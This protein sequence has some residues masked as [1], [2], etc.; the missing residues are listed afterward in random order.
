[1]EWC[2]APHRVMLTM[3]GRP[4]S[5]CMPGVMVHAATTGLTTVPIALYLTLMFCL[6]AIIPSARINTINTPGWTVGVFF[7]LYSATPYTLRFF[8]VNVPSFLAQNWMPTLRSI[9][10]S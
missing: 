1:M 4:A 10:T 2:F 7:A 3:L 8:K 9:Y 5:P 6:S